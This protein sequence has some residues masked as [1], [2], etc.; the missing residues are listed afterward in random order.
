MVTSSPTRKRSWTWSLYWRSVVT[1][2][3]C[4]A[5]ALVVQAV[6][7][8][9]WLKSTPDSRQLRA[10]TR[11]VASDVG[12]ALEANPSLDVQHFL[13]TH[14]PK[15]LATIYA[16]LASDGRS[17]FRGPLRPPDASI[18]GAYDFYRDNPHP[19]SLPES[20]IASEY[21]VTP[22]MVHGAV[23]GGVGAI[24]VLSW[25]ELIGWKMAMLSAVLLLLAT[26]LAGV[27]VFGPV[28]RQL[29]DL[30]AVAR[31]YGAGD[32]GARA[33][34]F[35]SDELAALAAAFNRMAAD[36][37]ARD[38]QLRA[39]DRQRRLLLADVSHELMTPL[40]AIRG[41]REVLSMSELARDLET[42]HGLDVIADETSRLERLVGDLL[43]LARLEAGG[44]SL[45]TE[46]VS[47]ESL[48]GRV[49][50]RHEPDARQKGVQV[51]TS[52]AA[53]AEILYGD[54]MRLEQALQN[55]AANAIRHTPAGGEIEVR[56]ELSGDS[57][58]LSVR[59]NGHGIPAEHLPFVFDRFYKVDPARTG[60]QAVRS[61]LGLSIVK[62]IVERHGGSV[63]AISQ[64]GVATVFTIQLPIRADAA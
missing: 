18:K 52:V 24:T 7:V 35:G 47:V 54:A 38:E 15:P 41:H 46:D 4:L 28:R 50:V 59:D 55:L 11:A 63:S 19:A 25:K 58:L 36:L 42:S 13:D 45:V 62:A 60:D 53:G 27:F 20:W 32:F 12:S 16:V 26:G 29:A 14:Y 34:E 5:A 44:E 40:T 39:S 3:A 49:A 57:V 30:E 56:A 23:A 33:Q 51:T 64:P 43:D 48:I 17:I 2:S 9:L 31:R 61:G 8:Q 22:I 6:A 1:V 37:A 21:Q 10:F